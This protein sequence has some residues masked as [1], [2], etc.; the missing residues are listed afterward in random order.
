MPHWTDER[1]QNIAD[2]CAKNEFHIAS[3]LLN[4]KESTLERYLREA[5]VRGIKSE[6]GEIE[7]PHQPNILILD[8]ENSPSIVASWGIR[9]QYIGT[10]YIVREWYMFSWALKYLH[11]TEIYSDVITPEES[12]AGDDKRILENLWK[13]VNYADI[14]I[15][16]NMDGFDKKKMNSRFIYHGIDPPSGYQTV[17]TL[18]VARSQFSFTSNKLDYIARLLGLPG[19]EDKGDITRWLRCMEGS[20]EDL[21]KM[22]KYN[23]GDITLTEDV[24][25]KLRPYIK[26]HPNLG[27]FGNSEVDVCY[28]CGSVDID[29]LEGDYYYTTVNKFKKYRCNNCRTIGRSHF[30]AITAEDR[31]HLTVAVAK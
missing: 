11:G 9:K 2:V 13:F 21:D 5:S 25:L 7:N 24:Y 19:K 28:K 14:I 18:K 23:R 30:S 10:E 20:Q 17:D 6:A 27:L 29:Y 31:K 22:H 1:L 15:G 4:I 16:H 8:I 12:L 3:K 26:G